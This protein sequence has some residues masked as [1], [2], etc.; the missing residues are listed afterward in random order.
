MA[1]IIIGTSG[2]ISYNIIDNLCYG[3]S[4]G[5]IIINNIVFDNLYPQFINYTVNWTSTNTI[6]PDQIRDNGR[7]LIDLSSGIYNFTVNSISTSGASLGPYNLSLIDPGA[8]TV[9]NIASSSYSCGENG[10]ISVSVSGGSPPYSFNIGGTIINQSGTTCAVDNLEPNIYQVSV[11]DNNN[12]IAD[13]TNVG[14][15]VSIENQSL[16]FV[17]YDSLPPGIRG[18]YGYLEVIVIGYGPFS[19]VFNSSGGIETTIDS[20]SSIAYQSSFDPTTNEYVFVFDNLLKTDNYTLTISNSNCNTTTSIYIPDLDIISANLSISPNISTDNFT[21]R[22]LLSIFDTIFIPFKHIQ[23]NSSLWQLVQQF[24]NTGRIDLKIGDNVVQ[25]SIVRNFLFPDSNNNEI[26]ILRLDNNMQNWFFCFHVAPGIDLATNMNLLNSSLSIIDKR[27]QIEHRLVFGLEDNRIS[28]EDASLLIGSLIIPGVNTNYYN[29]N[30]THVVVSDI[31][32]QAPSDND[33]LIKDI[34]TRTY[35]SLYTLGYTTNIY[36]LENFNVLTQNININNTACTISNDDFQYILNIKKLLLTMNNINN[37]Q[38]L[39]TYDNSIT[40]TG[41]VYVSISGPTSIRQ[42][43]FLVDNAYNIEYFSFDDKSTQLESFYLNNQK[44]SGSSITS[45][46]ESYMIIRIKDLNNNIV[47]YV[48]INE[49][50]NIPYSEHFSNALNI[51]QEYNSNIKPLFNYGD[52]LA[53]VTSLS[54]SVTESESINISDNT[55]VNIY[56]S[57]PKII[58]QSNDLNN[59]SKIILNTGPG[60]T[61]CY[62]LGPKNYKQEFIGY[63]IFENVVQGVYNIIGNE[64]YLLENFLYQNDIRI[65]V[66]KNKEYNATINFNSYKNLVFKK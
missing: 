58:K 63:T 49:S 15:T 5:S 36:F 26:E 20:I 17:D 62:L 53:I 14:A 2:S 10:S 28:Y 61:S 42:E 60:N 37:Y 22:L 24:I 3:G 21:S 55:T 57:L 46:A 7:A 25:Y 47:D 56:N 16:N 8:F 54:S 23:E 4:K 6:D 13:T 51:L 44:V 66:L 65:I 45:L 32:P 33:F 50:Q 52:I 29:G 48:G 59:T 18:G 9:S 31:V 64:D 43:N 30:N 41:S 11:L 27:N 35:L 12:C 34:K 19:F 38:K 39:Y 1:N 40:N